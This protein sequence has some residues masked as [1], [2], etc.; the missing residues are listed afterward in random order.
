MHDVYAYVD[1]SMARD[2]RVAVEIVLHHGIDDNNI[3]YSDTLLEA[4]RNPGCDDNIG[5][6]VVKEHYR[7]SA[8]ADFPYSTL[9]QDE[10]VLFEKLG[11]VFPSGNNLLFIRFFVAKLQLKC[12]EFCRHGYDNS[13]DRGCPSCFLGDEHGGSKFNNTGFLCRKGGRTGI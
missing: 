6:E 1:D 5:V 2:K 11:K 12:M 7:R 10:S 3:S 9:A 4:A 8:T 13:K